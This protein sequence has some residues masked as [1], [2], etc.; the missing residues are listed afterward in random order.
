M[1]IEM[2]TNLSSCQSRYQLI[3]NQAV[4][5]AVLSRLGAELVVHSEGH[6]SSSESDESNCCDV[7]RVIS[8][9]ARFDELETLSRDD[10]DDC[11]GVG[12]IRSACD[13]DDVISAA[14]AES[15]DKPEALGDLIMNAG[16]P[17]ESPF[18]VVIVIVGIVSDGR[19]ASD[20]ESVIASESGGGGGQSP[21][22]PVDCSSGSGHAIGPEAEW[23]I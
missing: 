19:S 16:F 1:S 14:T 18:F 6:A 7:I 10:D 9:G 21:P 12:D 20:F 22:P 8:D 13:E 4:N 23:D 3:F 15:N 17:D 5:Q 2:S 11:V